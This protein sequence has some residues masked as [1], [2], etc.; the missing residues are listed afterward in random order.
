MDKILELYNIFTTE[1]NKN[2]SRLYKQRILEKYKQDKEI[3]YLLGFIFNNLVI[4]G[5]SDKK[6]NKKIKVNLNNKLKINNIIELCEYLKENNTG[7]DQDILLV[8]NYIEKNKIYSE[9]I[10]K[11]I[12]KN[13]ILGIQTKTINKIFNNIIP[14]FEV[15]L[16]EKYFEFPD[17]IKN[18]SFIIDTKIDGQRLITI[19]HNNKIQFFNRS[20]Q[21][22]FGLVEIEKELMESQLKEFVLDGELTLFDKGNLSSKEQYQKTMKIARKDGEKKGLKILV[23]D[24]MPYSNFIN[25]KC[26]A[27][28]VFRRRKLEDIFGGKFKHIEVLKKLYQ[29]HDQTQIIKCL[30]EQIANGEEGVMVKTLSAPYCFGRTKDLLKVKRMQDIDTKII[31]LEEGNNKYKNTLGSLIIKYKGNEVRVGAGLTDELRN[32]IWN[33][34]QKYIG[35]MIEVQYFEET[36]NQNG[37]YSLRFPVFKDFRYDKE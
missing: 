6:L 36:Q 22:L 23:F 20:G 32:E 30:D 35:Q 19:K 21:E 28:Y 14:I 18:K 11:I 17:Y 24:L 29:G 31:G 12:T 2:N 13:L 8:Q 3:K 1:I 16:A 26:E 15:Q 34:K 9:L 37:E 7:K 27:G 25:K 5:I 33:N 4:T 10:R